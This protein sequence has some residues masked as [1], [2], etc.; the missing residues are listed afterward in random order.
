MKH[1]LLKA[2]CL[3]LSLCLVISLF[4]A[5]YSVAVE[6]KPALRFNADGQFKIMM[7]NDTQDTDRANPKLI[8]F[9]NAALDAENP[10]LVVIVGDMM[11]ETF[12]FPNEKRVQKAIDNIIAPINDRGIPFAIAFGNHDEDVKISKERQMQMYMAYDTCY[13]VDEGDAL[14]GVGTY[15]LP[16][17]TND[18]SKVAFN[19]Y[20][21]DSNSYLPGGGY[22]GVYEDQ[23][24]W[25]E[26]T[27]NALKAQNGG[28][29][30]PSLLF[31]H[32]PVPEI[33][34]LLT[35]V[36]A[37]TPGAVRDGKSWYMLNTDIAEGVLL[38]TPCP[39]A[40]NRGQYDSWLKQGDIV[41]A[42]FGHDHV[43]TFVGTT[44]DGMTMGYN[45][46]TGFRAYG[47][48]DQR[49]IRIF[50]LD[51]SSPAQYETHLIYYGDFMNDRFDFY[52]SDLLASRW[53]DVI[54]LQLYSVFRLFTFGLIAL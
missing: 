32:I 14:T 37:F 10:D 54:L 35:E 34:D 40:V 4:P 17:L 46:G 16:I 45:G 26:A 12:L 41:G 2:I 51:Q 50:N 33:F 47:N 44:P 11:S 28:Q 20:M 53:L 29:V 42:F 23:I 22:D 31:Q 9:L 15:N 19:V 52:Y 38:E 3:S 30:V 43:N 27:G 36:P 21:M 25:Y 7:I 6:E 8:N 1:K 5:M 13:A 39:S 48:G 18:G 49:T 24:A